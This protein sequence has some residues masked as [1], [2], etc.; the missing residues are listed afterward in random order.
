M[1]WMNL[2]D[3]DPILRNTHKFYEMTR[4]EAIEYNLKKMRRLY[5]LKKDTLFKNYNLDYNPEMV[6]F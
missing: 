6:Q 3:N 4:E 5:E 2:I 1:D